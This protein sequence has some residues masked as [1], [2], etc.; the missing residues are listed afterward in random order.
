MEIWNLLVIL[1]MLATVV[2]WVAALLS[3]SRAS[4]SGT[5]LALWILIVV[6][7]PFIGA[8]VWFLV[9]KPRAVS[10]AGSFR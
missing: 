6:I 2:L 1:P 4:L 9:G 8:I 10:G 3:I 7:A 5:E